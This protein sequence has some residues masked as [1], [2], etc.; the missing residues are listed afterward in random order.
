MPALP[1]CG[2]ERERERERETDRDRD[3]DRQT[4]R[5]TDRQRQRQR[6]RDTETERERGREGEGGRFFHPSMHIANHFFSNCHCSS[7]VDFI[8]ANVGASLP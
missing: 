5:Q 2:G 4:D 6:H 1:C 7:A 8:T 3:R